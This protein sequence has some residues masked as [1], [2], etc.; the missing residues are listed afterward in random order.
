LR[1]RLQPNR[2]V[3]NRKDT[4]VRGL[5]A[6]NLFFESVLKGDLAYNGEKP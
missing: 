1:E 4:L 3:E 2:R 5:P 6:K